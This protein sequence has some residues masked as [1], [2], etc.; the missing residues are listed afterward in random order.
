MARAGLPADWVNTLAAIA[1]DEAAH[2]SSVV[3]LLNRRGGRLERTHRNPYAN[4]LRALVRKGRGNEELADR[5]LISA[6]IEAR[7]CERLD[8]LAR[9]CPDRELAR[10]YARLSSSELG[11][12]TVFVRLAGHVLSEQDVS[13]RWRELLE[14]EA[15]LIAPSRRE[16]GCMAEF[17]SKRATTARSGPSDHRYG[18]HQTMIY[19]HG[20]TT[21]H[22]PRHIRTVPN[23]PFDPS[24]SVEPSQMR[25]LDD[26]S[27]NI[28][29]I[30]PLEEI[31]LFL[32]DIEDGRYDGKPSL[33]IEV[34]KLE[35]QTLRDSQHLDKKT[36]GVLVRKIH[37]P[38]P[39]PLAV[40]DV[41]TKIG[42]Y[43]IDKIGMV[44]IEGD[45]AF[46]F[47]YLVQ[48][49]EHEGRI[50]VTVL[51]KGVEI[52]LDVPV[53]SDPRSLFRDL[54]EEPSSY[55]IFGPLVFAEA[56]EEYVRSMASYVDKGG[57]GGSL[58]MIYTGIP[59]FT[60]YGDDQR[61]PG[62]RIVIIPSPMFSHKIGRGYDDP[63]T[64]A[65]SEVNGVRIRNLK[66]LVELLRDAPASSWNSRS[67]AGSPTRLFSTTKRPWPPP[68][69]S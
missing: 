31:T 49:L 67:Q 23:E 6:L 66:H 22:Y 64:Q 20:S 10:F 47:Q 61:F 13:R 59:A 11:H 21:L 55:F 16:A 54:T 12:Y 1:S 53:D 17:E 28:G 24:R 36:G 51:R 3:R 40:D 18:L 45:R 2:L 41:L 56:S 29:Y 14:A 25:A 39:Y 5:L 32:K 48:R 38:D 43:S 62:E 68:K 26:K 33:P 50:P 37:R 9:C 52:K 7:S 63:Y 30:I 65:V 42:N 15:V 60:R 58:S 4:A 34:Q 46:K 19:M 27:D 8:V 35:S 57:S 69:K 44:R